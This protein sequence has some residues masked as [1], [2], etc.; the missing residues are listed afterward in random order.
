MWFLIGF[1]VGFVGTLA[2]PW[3]LRKLG[4]RAMEGLRR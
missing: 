3:A 1:G 2:G 4:E